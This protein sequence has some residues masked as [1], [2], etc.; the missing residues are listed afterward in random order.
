MAGETLSLEDAPVGLLEQ[1]HSLG[2]ASPPVTEDAEF[3]LGFSSQPFKDLEQQ[4]KSTLCLSRSQCHNSS[5]LG[6]PAN[7]AIG[8]DKLWSGCS[9]W[10]EQSLQHAA[11]CSG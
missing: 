2:A 10:H 8:A 6:L 7:E 3:G 9:A 5:L 1:R 11:G 4:Q